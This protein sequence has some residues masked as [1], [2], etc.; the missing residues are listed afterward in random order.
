MI[1]AVLER[2][3]HITL[4]NRDIYVNVVGGLRPEG[5]ST[6]LAAA[7]AIWSDEKGVKLP[8]GMLAIGEIGL[9]GD[10]RPVQSAEKLVKEA[11][12]LGFKTVLLPARSLEKLPSRPDGIKLV[13][14]R[15]LL[16]AITAASQISQKQQ[17]Q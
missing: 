12:R 7:L 9:T 8:A 1:I 10:L 13:G 3:A 16:E 14:V 15:T 17:L 2:K 4:I 5:T 11:A 6:D